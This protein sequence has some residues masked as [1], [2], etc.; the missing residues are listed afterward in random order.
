MSN[1]SIIALALLAL[2]VFWAVGAYNRL[3]R[4]KNAIADAFAAIDLQFKDRHD[5]LLKLIEAAGE[6]LQHERATLTGLM[7]ARNAVSS[8]ND[9]VRA[10]PAAS[11][12]V[13]ALQGAE[14]KL[15]EQLETLWR[16][17]ADTL[18]LQ[19]DL[20]VREL[21]QQLVQSQGQLAFACQGFNH[22]VGNFNSAR[23]QFPPLLVARLFGLQPALKLS[24][25]ASE[26]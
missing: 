25:G 22:C 18:A 14:K 9:A 1:Q 21:T 24:V 17:A 23:R 15:Q 7:Q 2:T 5:I 10:R 16:V 26:M 20:R 8:A 19:A 11:G 13:R 4:L 6:Y 3:M 12:P